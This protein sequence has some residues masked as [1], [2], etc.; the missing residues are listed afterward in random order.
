MPLI[1]GVESMVRLLACVSLII[2]AVECFAGFKIM[3]IM[4]AVW[5]FFIGAFV[6][7]VIGLIA[8][9]MA[10]GVVMIIFIGLALAILSFKLYIA[11]IFIFT[12]FMSGVAVYLIFESFVVSAWI[13]IA[14]GVLAV[15]FVKPVVI[16]TT[17]I[18]GAGSIVSSA[19]MMMNLGLDENRMTTT[20]L[21]IPIALAGIVVQFI[22]TQKIK[23]TNMGISTYMKSANP[24]MTFS[25]RKYPGMQ[26]AYRNFCIKCGCELFDG[27]SK[28][29]RCG[30][31]YDD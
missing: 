31:S 28:C 7:V 26:R 6:G 13:G 9:S 4:M 17:A 22:T 3:K 1:E 19:Y 25:E 15:F 16:V 11:G 29:P 14:I 23:G 27:V 2:G 10:M 30:Y 8:D 18:S 12:A 5:G 20:L 24:S 21:W